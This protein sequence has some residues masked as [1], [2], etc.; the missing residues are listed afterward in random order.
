NPLIATILSSDEQVFHVDSDIL[1]PE[2]SRI[3]CEGSYGISQAIRLP[4]IEARILKLL[5]EW[6]TD[7]KN[8]CI[9]SDNEEGQERS[10]ENISEI[11]LTFFD[12]ID[13]PTCL[14]LLVAAKYLKIKRL[15]ESIRKILDQRAKT[16]HFQNHLSTYIEE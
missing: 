9:D 16:H 11:E 13:K 3:L 2:L 1:S 12:A 5:I 15:T 8:D 7:H 4:N 10:A 6:L 14:D